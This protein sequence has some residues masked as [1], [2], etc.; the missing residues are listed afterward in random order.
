ML[1]EC[2]ANITELLFHEAG[3]QTARCLDSRA[4]ADKQSG[5]NLSSGFPCLGLIQG[6]RDSPENADSTQWSWGSYT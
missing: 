5:L 6:P 1:T 4:Y 2:K 3:M